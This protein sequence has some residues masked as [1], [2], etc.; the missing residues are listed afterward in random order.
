MK[1]DDHPLDYR[2]FEGVIPKGSYGA[3]QVI[4]W[5]KGYYN[6]PGITGKKENEKVLSEGL[7]KGDLKFILHG[8]KLK[9]E[10]ALVRMKSAKQDNAWLLIKK[11]DEFASKKD[12][13]KEDKSVISGKTI[14]ALT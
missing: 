14:E 7:K 8:E 13:L 10:F 1:V 2:N 11:K 6:A 4:V 5:D 12:I 3:G 9:G